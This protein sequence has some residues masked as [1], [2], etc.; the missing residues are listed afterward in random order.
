[1]SIPSSPRIRKALGIDLGTTNSVVSML[2]PAGTTL[3]TGRDGQNRLTFPSL[4]AWDEAAQQLTAGHDARN[5]PGRLPLSSIKRYMG[6]DKR[7]PVGPRSLTA[8]EVSAVILRHL[9]GW[10]ET[11]LGPDA[12]R[13]LLDLAVITMPAYFNH[14]QIEATRL[15]GELAGFEVAELLHE[16]TAA[17]IFYSWIESH[18]DATYLVY[19]LGG[20]T[21]DVSIIRRRLGDHEVLAVSGDPFLGGDDFDRSLA[22]HLLTA[23][24]WRLHAPGDD[25]SGEPFDPLQHFDPTGEPFA[26]LVRQAESLKMELSEKPQVERY[27][28]RLATLDDGRTVS[29]EFTVAR[30]AFEKLIRE[31]CVRTIECCHE[32]LGRARERAGIRLSDIDHVILVGGSS[33]VP[34][35]RQVVQEAF[36]NPA[37]PERVKS[38]SLLCHEPDLAVAYGA[39]LRAAGHGTRFLWPM[40]GGSLELH[41][42]S[43]PTSPT[44]EYEAAGVVR[45]HNVPGQSLE[46][47]S[48]RL[49]SAHTGLIDEAFL[50]S[51]GAFTQLT[52]VSPDGET[53]LEWTVCDADGQPQAAASSLV[54]CRPA[55]RVLGQGV[56][57]TQLITRPLAIEVLTRGRQ[58]VK[59]T[60]APVGA[61]LPGTFRCVCRTADQSG[62]IVVPIFEDNRVIKHLDIHGLDP[63]LP[64]GSPVEVTFSIDARHLIEVSVKV[65]SEHRLEHEETATIEPPP[66]PTRPTRQEIEEVMQELEGEIDQLSGRHRTRLKAKAAQL[67]AD[68]LE[69]LGYDDEARAIQRMSE[70]RGLVAQ[71]ERI[72]GLVLDPPWTRFAQ[73][74]RHAM[75]NAAEVADKTG[76]AREELFGH[77]R[78]QEKYAE[79][80]HDEANQAL[81][82]ECWDNLERYANYLAQLLRDA[83]PRPLARPK[84]DPEQEAREEVERFR[85]LLSSVWK[86]AREKKRADLDFFMGEIARQAS[87]LSSRMKDDPVATIKE[88]RKLSVEIEKIQARMAEPVKPRAED[89]GGLLEGSS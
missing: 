34:L 19:D 18:G 39:A 44:P 81:Y 80:A 79:Q 66:P 30:P 57:A 27:V 64:V 40:R 75:D 61:A 88:A 58:R 53:T 59:Q 22:S 77:I 51:R 68:L 48:V 62:R 72:R 78:A 8:P 21:F 23:G 52:E 12:E 82:K 17:A 73:L 4:V 60:V 37:L 2:D 55:G 7:F 42:T 38:P 10:M 36:A 5:L 1:M 47:A 20:G 25:S 56:L 85:H 35:V 45:V 69:A 11:T 87:G 33:R 32:A 28:P 86:Q 70:L 76:R 63:L 24:R 65:K 49:R 50:D 14:S 46:G 6:L 71:A 26:R 43:P 84:R 29:V 74:V 9:R 54:G 31:R 13:H 89:H 15:A 16:P 41:V 83:L 67:H 3:L